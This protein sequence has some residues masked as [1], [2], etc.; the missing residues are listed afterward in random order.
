MGRHGHHHCQH[1][2]YWCR[3]CQAVYCTRCDQKWEP[4]CTKNHWNIQQALGGTTWRPDHTYPWN[5][6]TL[7]NTNFS[8]TAFDQPLQ[9]NAGDALGPLKEVRSSLC[10]HSGH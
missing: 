9:H 8:G 1:D 6:P 4:P 3:D 5:S 10:A 2:V 7:C